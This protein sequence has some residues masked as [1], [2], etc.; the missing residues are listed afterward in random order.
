MAAEEGFEPSHT[1]SESAVL[2]LHNSAKRIR[3]FAR[4]IITYVFVF[5][6]SSFEKRCK[7]NMNIN[8]KFSKDKTKTKTLDRHKKDDIIVKNNKY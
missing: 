3:L 4:S 2:P 8:I 5:V 1:E 7:K 6:N